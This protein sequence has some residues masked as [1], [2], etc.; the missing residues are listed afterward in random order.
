[1]LQRFARG[2]RRAAGTP[3]DPDAQWVALLTR[4]CAERAALFAPQAER[5]ALLALVRELLPPSICA[6]Q[7]QASAP[8]QNRH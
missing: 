4:Q 7:N 1:L 8:P 2:L 3:Q 6:G 5:A